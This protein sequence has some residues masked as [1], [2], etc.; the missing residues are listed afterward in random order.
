[1]AGLSIPATR[2]VTEPYGDSVSGPRD[3]NPGWIVSVVQET[4]LSTAAP[5]AM[6]QTRHVH[7]Q[8]IDKL[9][10]PC[11]DIDAAYGGH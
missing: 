3:T 2:K 1:V 4:A 5:S 9:V 8:S 6:G 11:S 10:L 7:P